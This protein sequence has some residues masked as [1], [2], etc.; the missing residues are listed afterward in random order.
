[1]EVE[2]KRVGS[3]PGET[4]LMFMHILV[5]IERNWTG[6]SDNEGKKYGEGCKVQEPWKYIGQAYLVEKRGSGWS[7]GGG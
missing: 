4:E 5:K 7:T 1:V 3:G 2:G 6:G